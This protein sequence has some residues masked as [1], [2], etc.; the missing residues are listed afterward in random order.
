MPQNGV[1]R[2]F[3]PICVHCCVPTVRSRD[4]RV[5]TVYTNA[6]K[7][8]REPIFSDLCTLLRSHRPLARPPRRNSVH[9]CPRTAP[10]GR[11]RQSVYTPAPSTAARATRRNRASQQ[12]TQMPQNGAESPFRPICVHSCAPHDRSRNRA[13]LQVPRRRRPHGPVTPGRSDLRPTP[14]GR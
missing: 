6:P 2:P 5:A 4:P 11:F 7:R 1:E 13:G 8:L 12:C 3:P 10:R 9:K 14:P